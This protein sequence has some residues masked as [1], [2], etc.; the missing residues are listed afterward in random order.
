MPY[1]RAADW[2]AFGVIMYEMILGQ[3]P[4]QGDDADEIYN[5]ILE[6]QPF[7]PTH[8]PNDARD[9]IQKLLV[10]EPEERLGYHK[11]AEEIMNHQFFKLID[12]RALYMREVMPP[13]R[14]AIKGRS[15]VSNFDTEFTSPLPNLS[16]VVQSG[17]SSGLPFQIRL[18][19]GFVNE[20]LA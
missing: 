5:A 8:M 6:S 17:M 20:D 7:Y 16:P 9:L 12:W 19:E 2:W 4:F 11:G 15:D 10:P 1:G 18:C 14:P 13:F 3:V